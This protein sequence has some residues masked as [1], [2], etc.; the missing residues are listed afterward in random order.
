MFR[1]FFDWITSV[2][3][4]L[5]VYFVFASVISIFAIIQFD[6]LSYSKYLSELKSEMYLE[7]LDVRETFEEVI[8]SQS[9][10][11][12]ELAT[13][14]S[15]NPNITQ[16]QFLNRVQNIRSIDDSTVSIAAA[17]DLVIKLIY[18]FDGNEDALGLD[19]RTNDEQ[20]PMIQEMLSTG[21]EIITGPVNLAQGGL[22]MILRAPVYLTER[23]ANGNAM[24]PGDVRTPWGIVSLV[25]DYDEFLAEAGL[26][27]ANE[28]YDLA[29]DVAG[30]RK[31]IEGVFLYGDQA[32]KEK[33]PVILDFDFE[34]EDW[35]LYAT[36][37][38]GWPTAA[39]A[40]WQKRIGM[41][42]VAL[43]LLVLLLYIIWLSETRKRAEALLHNGI[44]ALAD[45]FVMFDTRD[46]LIVSNARYREMY[47]F[48]EEM[49]HYG[50]PFSD[51]V[52]VGDHHPMQLSNSAD[53]MAWIANRIESRRS[54]GSLDIEQHLTDGRVIK[55]SDRRMQDGCY[56]GL[57]VDVTELSHAKAA[58]EAASEAKTNFMGVLSHELRTPLTVILGVARIAKNPRLLKS[59]KTLLAAIED[60]NTDPA[61]VKIMMEEMFDQFS[62][63]MDRTIQ[64]GD[65]LLYLINEMLDIAKIESGSLTVEIAAHD[66]ATI[67]DPV[68]IQLKTLSQKKGLSFEVI[69]DTGQVY[70]DK[71][72]TQ[73]I[74]FNLVGNA[75]K[76]TASGHVKLKVTASQD[77]V[78]FEVSDSGPGIG[79]SDIESIFDVFFQVDSSATRKAGGTGMGLAISR[80]LAE[81]QGGSLTVES[82]AG[83][84]SS[85]T[86]SLPSAKPRVPS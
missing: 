71:V 69:R 66:I 86:L 44:E 17:P 76:F 45:G 12:R 61:D 53:E 24:V 40:Q 49:V 73:Q 63:L 74:L 25:L 4:W 18:P 23:D 33:D 34:F 14:I 37:K 70:A 39:E 8:H 9:L 43:A 5:W 85:F 75:I 58:A 31:G 81:L 54:G 6:R 2:G 51:Y 64:S 7:L 21:G 26:T 50:T 16:E 47:G 3:K 30:R 38:G 78:L 65:H 68:A 48:S 36:T 22:G 77:N 27:D 42:A 15:D 19:Y 72:R 32:V 84:G 46:R 29:I 28:D 57:Y 20:F 82:T 52:K 41:V 79:Q 80:N 83:V 10:V 59:S 67:V 56:V 62:N 35:Q 60:G 55:V 1:S 13:F 11:L